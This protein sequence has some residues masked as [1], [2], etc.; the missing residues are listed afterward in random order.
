M[1]EQKI[2]HHNNNENPTNTQNN[3]IETMQTQNPHS[4]ETVCKLLGI[5]SLS[6]LGK[7]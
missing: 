4:S 6:P 3:N 1:N 2:C 5:N 7:V